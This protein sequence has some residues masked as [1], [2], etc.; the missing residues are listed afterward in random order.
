MYGFDEIIMAEPEKYIRGTSAYAMREKEIKKELKRMK[1]Q[2]QDL[3]AWTDED[4][5]TFINMPAGNYLRDCLNDDYLTEMEE[6]IEML[7]DGN[8]SVVE[9]EGGVVQP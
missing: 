5:V 1:E 9:V 8:Y 7:L 3:D 4:L 2:Y 6:A